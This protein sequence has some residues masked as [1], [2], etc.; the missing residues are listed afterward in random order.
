MNANDDLLSVSDL[1][2]RYGT[3]TAVQQVSFG[4]QPG[5]TTAIVGTN[6]AG[7]STLARSLAGLVRPASGRIRFD[8]QDT[9]SLPAYRIR[10]LGVVYLPEERGVSRSLSVLDNLRLATSLIKGRAEK[11]E[12]IERA[13]ALFPALGSRLQQLAR[14]LSGGEQQMLALARALTVRP[15]LLIVDE[16]SLGLAPKM[17]DAVFQSLGQARAE[18]VSI[19]LI[20]QFVHRALDFADEC[21]IL[22]HGSVAW[23]G[24]STLART[25]VS[26]QYFGTAAP[27]P[28]RVQ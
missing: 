26:N 24:R 12:A 14:T 8:G 22:S 27:V 1:V 18:G 23:S 6:G 11:Q 25:E 13:V 5:S 20:E 15:K 21:V 10:R 16:M 3:L 2:V 9:T 7:K 17:V 28:D 4:I 19:L